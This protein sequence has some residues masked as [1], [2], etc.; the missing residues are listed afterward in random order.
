M[1]LW[2]RD[3]SDQSR[4]VIPVTP[5]QVYNESWKGVVGEFGSGGGLH[6]V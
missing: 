1:N 2:R 6:A 3:Q 5:K 4:P